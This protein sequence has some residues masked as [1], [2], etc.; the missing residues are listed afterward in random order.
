VEIIIAELM[1]YE[2]QYQHTSRHTN[3]QA[4]NI[5]NRKP[6]IPRNIPKDRGKIVLKHNA[7]VLCGDCPFWKWLQIQISVF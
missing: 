5:D 7:G 4:G 3:D 1:H 2:L 6:F